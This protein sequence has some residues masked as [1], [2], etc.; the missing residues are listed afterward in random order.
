MS[1][2]TFCSNRTKIGLIES[3]IVQ[4]TKLD[5]ISGCFIKK[6]KKTG[7][8]LIHFHS[9]KHAVEYGR[10]YTGALLNEKRFVCF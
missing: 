5:L 1:N 8:S 2:G 9:A 10:L 6:R 3:E 7:I 4:R